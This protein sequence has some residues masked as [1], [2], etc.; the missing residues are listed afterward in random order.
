[1]KLRNYSGEDRFEA[2]DPQDQPESIQEAIRLFKARSN[3]VLEEA[4]ASQDRQEQVVKGL[5][6]VRPFATL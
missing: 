1:M 5:K 4:R 6:H 2:K 3:K